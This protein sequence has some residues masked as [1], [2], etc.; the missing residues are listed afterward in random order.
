VRELEASKDPAKAAEQLAEAQ[1]DLKAAEKARQ[2]LAAD[3]AR[4]KAEAFQGAGEKDFADD[5]NDKC[6]SV[7]GIEGANRKDFVPI[8]LDLDNGHRAV[9]ALDADHDLAK[10]ILAMPSHKMAIELQKLADKAAEPPKK[11]VS[12]APEPIGK[13]RGVARSDGYR[14]DFT[15]QEHLDWV[16]KN[17]PYRP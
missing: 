12:K 2:M 5:W 15:V 8:L 7:A 1:I 16:K 10:K 13:A 14:S 3:T 4:Q 9:A 11:P 17:Q 6:N